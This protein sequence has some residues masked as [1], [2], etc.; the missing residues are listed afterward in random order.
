MLRTRGWVTFAVVAYGLGA[1]AMSSAGEPDKTAEHCHSPPAEATPAAAP[2]RQ[3]MAYTVPDVRLVRAD[4][5]E[6]RIRQELEDQRPVILNFIFTSCT[7]ICPVMSQTLA[8]V[9]ERLGEFRERVK[10]ISVSIDPEHDTPE[11]LRA[12]ARKYA[13][14]PQWTFYTGTVDA[15]A[16]LQKAFD[17]YRGNKMNHAPVTFVRPGPGQ[18]WT[19]LDGLGNAEAIAREVQPALALSDRR[20]P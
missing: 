19:R 15:S 5:K 18:P 16:A 11:R 13:A 4:G 10:M 3:R 1:P 17:A 2:T 6:V 7:T 8:K 12:Y 14:G 20:E 9:Q